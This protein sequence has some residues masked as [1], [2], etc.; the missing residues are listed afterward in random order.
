MLNHMKADGIDTIVVV[1]LYP[2]F[3]VSTSGSSLKVCLCLA[4]LYIY[5][6]D[7]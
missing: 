3:S 4:L 7:K 5:L 2:H 1:P 6:E